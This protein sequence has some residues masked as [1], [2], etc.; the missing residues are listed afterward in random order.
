MAHP[1]GPP[2]GSGGLTARLV[3]HVVPR[4]A[5]TAVAGRHGDAIKIRIAA[6]PVNGAA[7]EALIRF[8]A[9]RLGVPRS[10]ISITAGESARR[11]TVSISGIDTSAARRLLEDR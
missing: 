10:A 2:R 7:N 3:L 5:T 1:D 6:P 4:A 9:T 11:K 8:L